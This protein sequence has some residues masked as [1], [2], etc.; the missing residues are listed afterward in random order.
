MHAEVHLVVLPLKLN[1]TMFT[2]YHAKVSERLRKKLFTEVLN[3]SYE[4]GVQERLACIAVFV[5]RQL[6]HWST[7]RQ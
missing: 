6:T 7:I 1:R 3:I 4:T 5:K 2:Q